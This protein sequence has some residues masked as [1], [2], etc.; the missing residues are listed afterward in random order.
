LIL[1]DVLSTGVS[2]SFGGKR[3]LTVPIDPRLSVNTA[4]AA[5]DAAA[6]GLGLT[7]VLS[8][9]ASSSIK[10]GRLRRVLETFEPPSVPVSVVFRGQD[11]LPLKVRAFVDFASAQLR[12]RLS[13]V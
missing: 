9:Q 1:F 11:T 2:W 8:Y 5:I 12:L 3:S 4:E 7:R 6:C 10:S 13:D